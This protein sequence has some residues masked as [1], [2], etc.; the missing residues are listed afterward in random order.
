M[1][2]S[3]LW[4]EPNPEGNQASAAP[5]EKKHESFHPQKQELWTSAGLLHPWC[6][7]G[8]ASSGPPKAHRHPQ[9]SVHEAAAQGAHAGRTGGP[10][11]LPR[12]SP[13]PRL[14]QRCQHPEIDPSHLQGRGTEPGLVRK[15]MRPSQSQ[16]HVISTRF[17]RAE[18]GLAVGPQRSPDT[19]PAP[20]SNAFS[21]SLHGGQKPTPRGSSSSP[22][23]RGRC[24]GR[25]AARADPAWC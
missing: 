20:K 25:P 7:E 8:E 6:R 23:G 1:Q 13:A 3:R 10:P 22:G 14:R 9:S 19:F 16:P 12:G 18:A 15:S 17:S 4:Q 2:R 21:S 5:V 24:P 11:R